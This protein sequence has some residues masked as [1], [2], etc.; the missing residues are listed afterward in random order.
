MD[1]KGGSYNAYRFSLSKVFDLV[2]NSK[3]VFFTMQ[4]RSQL[5][6]ENAP[7]NFMDEGVFSYLVLIFSESIY[8]ICYF[9][10][11]TCRS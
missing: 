9:F 6:V 2:N 7:V 11:V 3:R 1:K 8:Q 4:S 10:C 5:E